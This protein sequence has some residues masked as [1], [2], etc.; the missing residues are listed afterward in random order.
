MDAEY[1]GRHKKDED[2]ETASIA[3][4]NKLERHHHPKQQSTSADLHV[5]LHSHHH[6]HN[7]HYWCTTTVFLYILFFSLLFVWI[8]LQ[9]TMASIYLNN[10]SS[11]LPTAE[12]ASPLSGS[13]N[14]LQLSLGSVASFIFQM[15][16]GA[17]SLINIVLR[18]SAKTA[19]GSAKVINVSNPAQQIEDDY[20]FIF[21]LLL[22]INFAVMLPRWLKYLS[23]KVKTKH[24]THDG[25]SKQ[26]DEGDQHLNEEKQSQI[27]NKLLKVYLPAYFLA[28][29]ADWLQGPYKY[30]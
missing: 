22:G 24:K 16:T 8:S 20:V 3:N 1:D 23:S 12:D 13:T 7:H 2:I 25:V 29:A 26:Q 27:H 15:K 5:H 14:I 19:V 4:T 17:H 10:G 18:P 21:Y 6:T 30:A 9:L 11:S 28:T